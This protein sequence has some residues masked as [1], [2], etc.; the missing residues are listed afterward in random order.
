M[1]WVNK[2]VKRYYRFVGIRR[3]TGRNINGQW[4]KSI[5]LQ[6][7]KWYDKEIFRWNIKDGL[8]DD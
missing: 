1:F 7:Y 2:I 4:Y 3:Y 5:H 6:I 8:W